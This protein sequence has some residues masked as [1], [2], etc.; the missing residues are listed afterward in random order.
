MSPRTDPSLTVVVPAYNEEQ[1]LPAFMPELL[2][3]CRRNQWPLVVVD[4]GSGDGTARVLEELGAGTPLRVV[5]HKLNRGYGGA[6]KSGIREART[7]HVAT[8]DAD[9][10]HHAEDLETLYRQLLDQDADMLVGSRRDQPAQSR[11]RE[12]GKYLLRFVARL[13][14]DLRVH[15]INSGLKIYDT[16][17]AQRY[18][19]LCP[20]SMAFSD[21][22]T[23]VF[24]SQRHRVIERPIRLRP[25]AGGQSTITA[26]TA[27]QTLM[28]ILNIV[29]LFNPHRVFLP[30]AALSL[31]GGVAWGLP[32]VLRGHGVSVGAMLAIVTGIVFFL[33]GLLA[34]QIS[35]IR[36]GGS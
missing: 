13:L 26:R 17:L 23:L 8:I 16:R 35:L 15:D 12:A 19:H 5:R 2:E 32:I 10:Q 21:V 29:V 27:L 4:D 18:L 36:R 11:Y 20:D 6:L 30:A 25:R 9:G 33:L 28:E 3:V 24:V 7:E 1:S 31:C 22:I 14:L 34:E